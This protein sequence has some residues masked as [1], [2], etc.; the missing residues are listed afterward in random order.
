MYNFQYFEQII[1]TRHK[2]L[3]KREVKTMFGKKDSKSKSSKT[4]KQRG[5]EASHDMADCGSK[6]SR[7]SKSSRASK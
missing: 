6:T 5:V 7:D 3:N 4:S 2:A 1:I